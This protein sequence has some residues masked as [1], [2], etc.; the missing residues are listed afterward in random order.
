MQWWLEQEPVPVRLVLVQQAS[1]ARLPVEALARAAQPLVE[2]RAPAV[3][4]ALVQRLP[5]SVD[6]GKAVR[7][8]R[9][10]AG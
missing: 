1:Q 5:S 2:R 9:A 8:A 3:E 10:I 4:S 7:T 6:R